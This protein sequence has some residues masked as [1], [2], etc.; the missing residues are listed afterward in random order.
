MLINSNGQAKIAD[1]GIAKDLDD[2]NNNENQQEFNYIYAAY[3]T[4]MMNR[5]KVESGASNSTMDTN[6]QQ[7]QIDSPPNQI[8]EQNT[9]LSPMKAIGSN[10]N[11]SMVTPESS[12]NSSY[13]DV[14]NHTLMNKID[15][16]T[17]PSPQPINA[18]ELGQG[19]QIDS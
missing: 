13:Q 4:E 16:L 5:M 15:H 2:K 14:Y 3:L 7:F 11:Q 8:F 6:Y 10:Q 9:N 18:A 1:F 19:Q 17:L 12:L